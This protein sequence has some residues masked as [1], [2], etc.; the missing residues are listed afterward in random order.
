MKPSEILKAYRAAK[1]FIHEVDE[2]RRTE[3]DNFLMKNRNCSLWGS[4]QSGSVRR[5]S[6]DLTRALARMRTP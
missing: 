6:M 4:M 3:R 1:H 2:L 5:A